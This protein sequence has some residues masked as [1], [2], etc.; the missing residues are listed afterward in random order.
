MKKCQKSKIEGQ[1]GIIRKLASRGVWKRPWPPPSE[2]AEKGFG[3][4]HSELFACHSERSEESLS[5]RAQGELREEP[6]FFFQ[7]EKQML[8]SAQHDRIKFFGNPEDV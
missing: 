2:V 4:C 8:R 7:S 3:P 5:F 1:E 6:K